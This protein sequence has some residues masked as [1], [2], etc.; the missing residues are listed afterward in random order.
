[1]NDIRFNK[2]AI[3]AFELV[4]L[5]GIHIGGTKDAF[6]IGGV[7]SPVIK[8]P[9]TK[10]PIIPGSSLK[11]KI[12]SLLELSREVKDNHPL[13][14]GDETGP[15]RVI[16]RDMCLTPDSAKL[17]EKTLGERTY[18]EI[19]AEN[20]IDKF[21]GTTKKGGLRFIERVPAGVNFEG[22]I[23]IN[24]YNDEDIESYVQKIHKGFEL[25]EY[26]FLGGSGSRGYGKIKYIV[27]K[28]QII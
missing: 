14:S 26:N 22:E 6:G 2:R 8:D 19:K 20:T 13:F 16:F 24:A 4:I 21:T 27:K 9:I 11:G 12:R 3:I 17:L 5:T 7:D 23:I 28:E 15:T 25:L 1:M 10:K 18:T